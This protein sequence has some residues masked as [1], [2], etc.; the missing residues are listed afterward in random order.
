MIVSSSLHSDINATFLRIPYLYG[1]QLSSIDQ[2]IT[3]EG[4]DGTRTTA[5]PFADNVILLTEEGALGNTYYV[6]PVDLRLQGSAALKVM[7]GHTLIKKYSEE[8]PIKE[9]T[10]GIA[11][12]FPAW[13]NSHRVMLMDTTH[14]TW[15]Y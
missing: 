11:N 15:Q 2:D 9:I 13:N 5:N 3:I 6:E 12:A 8:N 4:K 14:S 7:N 10:Q 1:I